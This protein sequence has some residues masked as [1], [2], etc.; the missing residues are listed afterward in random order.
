[1]DEAWGWIAVERRT[2]ADLAETLDADQLA[3]P[4]LCA[5]W[6]VRD[7]IAHLSVGMTFS[8]GQSAVVLLRSGFR[9]NRFIQN[10][11]A[12][13]AQRS[14]AEL[15]AVFRDH[16]D[17]SFAPPGL[18][19]GA[20][21]TD[22]LVHGVDLRRPLGLTHAPNPAALRR[23]LDF[24]VAPKASAGFARRRHHK[25]LRYEASDLEWSHGEGALVRGPAQP[26]LA[27]LCNRPA[28][29]DDLEGEGV[30]LLR[31]RLS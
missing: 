20:P 4:S 11:T 3:T 21:L 24:V 22:L 25:G 26:L 8:A 10:L 7:V 19:P 9:P 14:D 18:G 17:V 30:G 6:T 16:A 28:P 31:S 23:S 15:V 2:I 1:V 27:A 13:A 29:L 12:D 5:G